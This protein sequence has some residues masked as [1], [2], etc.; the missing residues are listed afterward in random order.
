MELEHPLATLPR[1]RG[2][3]DDDGKERRSGTPRATETISPFY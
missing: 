1:V 3:R 2:D